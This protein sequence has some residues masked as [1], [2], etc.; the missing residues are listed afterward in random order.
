V[1][2][3]FRRHGIFRRLFAHLQTLA[4]R[5]NDVRGLRLYMHAENLRARQSYERLGM[6][7]T[8]Y[9]VFEMALPGRDGVE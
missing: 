7:R 9:E 6:Q 3:E 2:E 5:R 4:A 1:K 8:H